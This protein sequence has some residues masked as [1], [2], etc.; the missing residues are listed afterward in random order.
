M[1]FQSDLNGLIES[2]WLC[3]FLRFACATNKG[4][5]L[6]GF[7]NLLAQSVEGGECRRERSV[8]TGGV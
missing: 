5:K 4:E 7:D 6:E 8:N 1:R 2:S 3:L